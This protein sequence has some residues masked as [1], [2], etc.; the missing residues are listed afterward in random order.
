MGW[1]FD[2]MEP[3]AEDSPK[4]FSARPCQVAAV[5]AVDDCLKTH[6][7]CYIVLATGIGKTEIAI[8]LIN[9]MN[10]LDG[11]LVI[12]PRIELVG[13]T[14]DR[15]RFR[16]IPCGVER[17]I[18]KSHEPVTVACYDSLLSKNRYER[19]VGNVKLVI[20][21]ESH[22]NYTPAAM[23]MLGYF[24]EAGAKVVGMTATPRAGK[25]NPLSEWYGECAFTY[26]YADG[27]RDGYLLNAKIWLSV[28]ESLDLSECATAY[29]DYDAVKVARWMQQ[30]KNLQAV[31]SLIEQ[32]YE[33]KPSVVFCQ[34]ITH[35]ELLRDILARRGIAA[36][37]IH[38]DTSRLP[39][40]ER[41]QSLLD[42]EAG[43]YQVVC[44][45]GCLTLGWDFPPLAKLYV[46]RPT[47]SLDLYGQIFGR[48][49]RPLPGVV[50]GLSTAEER[51]AA[52]AKSDKPHFEIYDFCDA[53]RHN[54]LIT[55]SDFLYPQLE[56]EVK[57]RVRKRREKSE[58]ITD[59]D[60]VI[61][62]ERRELA[63]QQAAQDMIEMSKR[64]KLVG[65]A[66][67]SLYER[68]PHADAE[69]PD[70]PAR[71]GYMIL[72][73]KHRGWP[74][75]KVPTGYLQWVLRDIRRTER[76]AY[77]MDAVAKEVRKR[78]GR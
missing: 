33:G 38:S 76:N 51:I 73:K 4:V 58:G 24:R 67:Y 43:K 17:G 78:T 36:C 15:L 41:R 6:D 16:G 13:Q 44:N 46:A 39:E 34:S 56:P 5:N 29:G 32:T 23:K 52:I 59:L 20:V 70:R 9:Q 10:A 1:L 45:V 75:A 18:Y 74:I 12:T 37:V 65:H 14:A 25:A 2:D 22:L 60:A 11:A 27:V 31:S 49:T 48:G 62:Q 64:S 71:Q 54:K 72:G 40:D 57:E 66:K 26:L 21:D 77:F 69:R 61:E 35:S 8:L 50:D 19:Y 63:R 30:E 7:S 53:S 47:Q 3:E 55:A 42:F 68:D 28:L